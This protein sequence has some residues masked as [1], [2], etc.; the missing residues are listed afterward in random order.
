MLLLEACGKDGLIKDCY[1]HVIKG[2]NYLNKTIQYIRL[3]CIV[4]L[5]LVKPIKYKAMSLTIN[6]KKLSL[7]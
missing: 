4:L 1:G 5:S 3:Y 7:N 6:Q 2:L